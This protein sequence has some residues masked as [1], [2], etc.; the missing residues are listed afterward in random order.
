MS[1]T[2][3]RYTVNKEIE[4]PDGK[5]LP[6]SKKRKITARGDRGILISIKRNP[7]QTYAEL[8]ATVTPQICTKTLQRRLGEHL[9]IKWIA[10]ECPLLTDQQA[11][12]RLQCARDHRGWTLERWNTM[13]WSDECSA[14]KGDGRRRSWVFKTRQQKW[15]KEMIQGTRPS[16]GVSQMIWGAFSGA[17]RFELVVMHGD[18][19]AKRGGVSSRSY[20]A[21]WKEHLPPLLGEAFTFMQDNAPIHKAHIIRNWF[22]RERI[23]GHRVAYLLS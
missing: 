13:I 19:E 12:I 14:S 6:R 21:T 8:Q 5:T 1:I 18:P 16:G 2:T 15:E 17:G 22:R 20:L 3:A 10:A 11:A 7:S 23:S 9:I 4:R